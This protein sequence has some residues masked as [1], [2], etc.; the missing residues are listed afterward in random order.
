M[1]IKGVSGREQVKG[2][3]ISDLGPG[4]LHIHQIQ[5]FS[6]YLEHNTKCGLCRCMWLVIM[7]SAWCE[8]V[9]T[10]TSYLQSSKMLKLPSCDISGVFFFSI[11]LLVF[12]VRT[13]PCVVLGETCWCVKQHL[14]WDSSVGRLLLASTTDWRACWQDFPG[15]KMFQELSCRDV[16]DCS[17]HSCAAY[18][19]EMYSWSFTGSMFDSFPSMSALYLK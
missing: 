10:F 13:D 7:W 16:P 17:H 5:Y 15:I 6:L 1:R 8:A 9:I 11:H 12:V 18:I 19:H 4:L 3:Q 14:I 2:I